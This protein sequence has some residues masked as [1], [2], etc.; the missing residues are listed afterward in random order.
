MGAVGGRAVRA[1][2]GGCGGGNVVVRGTRML[3]R[4]ASFVDE[5]RVRGDVSRIGA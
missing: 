3:E 4:G 2:E 1:A 5:R